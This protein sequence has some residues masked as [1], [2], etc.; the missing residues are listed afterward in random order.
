MKIYFL[1]FFSFLFLFSACQEDCYVED[2]FVG[3]TVYNKKDTTIIKIISLLRNYNNFLKDSRYK[4]DFW[5]FKGNKYEIPDYFLKQELA[6]FS[7]FDIKT[8]LIYIHQRD[9]FWIA[10]LA[11][12][13]YKDGIF[14]GTS[15]VYNY[16]IVV[17]TGKLKLCPYIELLEFNIRKN[18]CASFYSEDK[19]WL[20]Q[21]LMDS[22]EKHNQYLSKMFNVSPKKFKCYV[23]KNFS[24]LNY[25]VGL[26][27]QSNPNIVSHNA[28]CD[29]YN[30][31]MYVSSLDESFHELVHLYTN[32]EYPYKNMW[33]DEGFALMIG[34]AGDRD[35]NYH[36]N[37]LKNYLSK[38]IFTYSN[39]Q[40]GH[41]SKLLVDVGALICLKLY[42]KDGFTGISRLM[43]YE[44]NE[45][46][47]YKAIEEEFGIKRENLNE[48]IR[49]EIAKY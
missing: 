38:N 30:S 9:S 4:G 22:L 35:I 39:I 16:G 21:K 27:V 48:F 26:N 29:Y 46:G 11:Y 1:I 12:Q 6:A 40:V 31:I 28:Y 41:N 49:K 7:N 23:F 42:N 24:E 36:L 18:A 25:S 10:Q 20:N 33:F 14:K 19:S 47:F 37:Q 13:L 15:C 3:E 17:E 43:S 45:A 44:N 5:S 34:G 8:N 2:F 32:Q